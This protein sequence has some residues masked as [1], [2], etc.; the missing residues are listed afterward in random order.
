MVRHVKCNFEK[1]GYKAALQHYSPKQSERESH[2]KVPLVDTLEKAEINNKHATPSHYF[3]NKL[4]ATADKNSDKKSGDYR[5]DFETKMYSSYL[6]LIVGPLAYQTIHQNLQ[7]AIPSL[8]SVNRYIRASNCHITEGILRCDELLVYLKERNL[9]LVVSLAEDGTKV[10]DCVQYSSIHNQLV[11]FTLPVSSVSG[12]PIPLSYPARNS[13]EL[14]EHFSNGNSVSTFIN[15]IMAQPMADVP[16]FCL[17]VFGSD[18]RYTS[19]DHIY[20]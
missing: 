2:I 7:A 20:T 17:I 12:L 10:R 1:M 14:M 6:R 16:P 15:V 11:G 13:T 9:P 3:L 18:S 19:N 4:L 8:T 5:Y